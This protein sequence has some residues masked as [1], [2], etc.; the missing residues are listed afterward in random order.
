MG[1][2]QSNEKSNDQ[3]ISETIQMPENL[4][5]VSYASLEGLGSHQVCYENNETH[6]KH[7]FHL[8]MFN[9]RPDNLPHTQ[10]KKV[11]RDPALPCMK[12]THTRDIDPSKSNDASNPYMTSYICAGTS[13]KRGAIFASAYAN[14][15]N[16]TVWKHGVSSNNGHIANLSGDITN[17]RSEI[18]DLKRKVA[19][20]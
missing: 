17:L 20:N 11:P 13:D 2:S 19:H 6:I 7:R 16:E 8:D 15:L 18:D 9:N 5:C 14:M 1:A 10:S 3:A 12:I 4:E